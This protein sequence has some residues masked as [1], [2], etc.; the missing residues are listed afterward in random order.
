[1]TERNSSACAIA[2]AQVRPFPAWSPLPVI[3]SESASR[4][5]P[6]LYLSRIAQRSP[7]RI[8]VLRL[9]QR[10]LRMTKE[11]SFTDEA[12]LRFWMTEE[13]ELL[14]QK[15]RAELSNIKRLNPRRRLRA[16][17]G[18]AHR[19]RGRASPVRRESRRLRRESRRSR[20]R[21]RL[22][23]ARPRSSCAHSRF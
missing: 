3:P 20:R 11:E 14:R 1:M 9:A 16:A 6:D 22:R 10:S 19:A 5:T 12:S 8:G 21:A 13:T 2:A 23:C 17:D 18:G 15:N 4:G 7:G